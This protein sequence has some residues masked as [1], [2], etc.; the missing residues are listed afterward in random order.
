[1]SSKIKFNRILILSFLI[2][3]L[4]LDIL[5]TQEKSLSSLTNREACQLYYSSIAQSK[6]SRSKGM[7]YSHSYLD[8]GFDIK[9]DWVKDGKQYEKKL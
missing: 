1:M 5:Y 8:L 7:Y 6:D 2:F 3:L 9:Q 4:K